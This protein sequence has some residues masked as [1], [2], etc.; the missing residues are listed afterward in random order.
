MAKDGIGAKKVASVIGGSMGASS[1]CIESAA[2]YLHFI[3][4]L[5]VAKR[6]G[7]YIVKMQKIWKYRKEDSIR[8]ICRRYKAPPHT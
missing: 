2:V 6:V 3:L 4:L 8:L 7:L 1:C 5:I